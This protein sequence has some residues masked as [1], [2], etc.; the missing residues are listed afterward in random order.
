MSQLD[1]SLATP[2]KR[3]ESRIKFSTPESLTGLYF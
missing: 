1:P 3:T 2:F